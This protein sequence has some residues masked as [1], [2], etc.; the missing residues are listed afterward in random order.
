M[1]APTY[2]KE[3]AVL[4]VNFETEDN[5]IHFKDLYGSDIF[6]WTEQNGF[7][8]PQMSIGAL[9]VGGTKVTD[10][11]IAQGTSGIWQYWKYNS[12]IA[13]CYAQTSKTSAN[14]F[15]TG[16]WGSVYSGEDLKFGDYPF[17]FI[18]SPICVCNAFG[19]DSGYT[20][21]YGWIAL[22]SPTNY[23]TTAPGVNLIRPTDDIIG[24]PKF[25]MFVIGRWK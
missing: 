18:D 13:I 14:N 2:D 22:E 12:G 24:H 3:W 5:Q 4:S 19:A 6:R 10:Y 15:P 23:T 16:S 1:Y 17:S 8:A 21:K 25:R 20:G 9:A 7:Y 11:V